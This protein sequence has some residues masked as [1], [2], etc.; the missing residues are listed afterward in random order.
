MKVRV[1]FSKHGVVIY[2]GHLDIMRYFQKALRRADIPVKY[3]G[4][5][6][7]HQ[8]ISFAQPLGVGVESESEYFDMELEREDDLEA[9]KER[10]NAVMTE[11]IVVKSIVELPDNAKNAMA[12]IAAASYEVRFRKGMEPSF[13]LSAGIEDMMKQSA[14]PYVKQTKKNEIEVDLKQGIYQLSAQK[15]EE[16]YWVV[17]MTVDASSGGNIKPSTI[18]EV[19][20]KKAEKELPP[21]GLAITRMEIFS[22]DDAGQLIPL[23]QAN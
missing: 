12:S 15:G 19:L 23:I 7:P 10:L 18:L 17:F 22:K 21:F 3:T 9:M 14:I 5:F 13:D 6:S 8:V 4:G 16:N 2:I 1:Q 20:Y 11:G